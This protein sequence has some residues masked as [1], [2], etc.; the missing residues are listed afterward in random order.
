[1]SLVFH[2]IGVFVSKR[3]MITNV[4]DFERKF[5]KEMIIHLLHHFVLYFFFFQIDFRLMIHMIWQKLA[6]I[7]K[8]G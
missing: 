6:K 2:S 5:W 8:F 1:M 7:C 3:E 4:V